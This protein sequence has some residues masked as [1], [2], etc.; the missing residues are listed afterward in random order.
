MAKEL[1]II[2]DFGSML[3]FVE[4]VEGHN[5]K[6]QGSDNI[7]NYSQYVTSHNYTEWAGGTFEEALQ[8][9]KTGWN[10]PMAELDEL[11]AIDHMAAEMVPAWV[12]EVGVSGDEVDVAAFVEG[13]PEHM[14]TMLPM[15]TRGFGRVVRIKVN[16][17]Y[18]QH[19]STAKIIERGRVLTA[20]VDRLYLEGLRVEI[21][22]QL[23]T[24]R[25]YRRNRYHLQYNIELVGAGGNDVSLPDVM[26]AVGHPTMLRR[27]GF[28]A[29]ELE[30][31]RWRRM[32]IADQ[33]GSVCEAT[34]EGE[35]EERGEIRIRVLREGR[36]DDVTAWLGQLGMGNN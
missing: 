11:V 24:E 31:E 26:Y 15:P 33:Y 17:A 30:G 12:R 36:E 1:E 13:V 5:R 2:R 10:A 8:L 22:V 7:Y 16:C 6:L 29:I 18:A 20:L 4:W 9:A 23:S 14:V 32:F 35:A 21:V 3:E 19:I 28:A 27:L 25:I 34:N